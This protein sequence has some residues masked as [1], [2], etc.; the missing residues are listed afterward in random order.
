MILIVWIYGLFF[1][2]VPLLNTG[3]SKYVP[4]G[5]LTACSFEYLDTSKA[6]KI[7]MFIYFLCAY[8][9]PLIIITYCYFYILR[10][11]LTADRL[12]SS[13]EKNKTEI[14]LALVVIGIIGIWFLSWSPYAVVALLGIT[15]QEKYLTPLGSMIPAV[16]CKTSAV[17]N[18]LIY[19]INHPRFKSELRRLL[20]CS[21]TDVLPDYRSS[22]VSKQMAI[23][24]SKKYNIK[25]E[26]SNKRL[27]LQRGQSSMDSELS[28]SSDHETKQTTQTDNITYD[29]RI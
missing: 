3:L 27:Q 11:V 10:I 7:F 17:L 13:K 23:K 24:E 16:F 2:I 1:S 4:E 12:Q 14:K 29:S 25:E 22:Y 9:L 28:Y 8:I 18:P 5:F 26:K 15:N 6:A 20:G 19:A 21:P